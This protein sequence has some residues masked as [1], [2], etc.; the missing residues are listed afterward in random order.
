MTKGPAYDKGL[1]IR[2][3]TLGREYVEAALTNATDLTRPFQEFVTEY[4]WGQVWARDDVQPAT[5]SLLT[6]AVLAALG[7][8]EELRLHMEAA[9]RNGCNS[10]ELRETLFQVGLYAGLPAAVTGFRILQEVVDNRA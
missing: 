4:A 8:R 5:R 9:L 7:E 3:R 10:A 1:E 6:V 2:K